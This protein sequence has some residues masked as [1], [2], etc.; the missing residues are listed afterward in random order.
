MDINQINELLKAIDGVEPLIEWQEV[1]TTQSALFNSALAN[2]YKDKGFRAYL[3][4]AYRV[5]LKAAALK[6]TDL[7]SL[8]VAKSRAVLLKELLIKAENA[9]NRSIREQELRKGIQE[10][11]NHATQK[12]KESEGDR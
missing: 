7:M 5:S 2:M 4:E 10:N 12:R 6:S 9:F 8:A 3:T 11:I 1:T